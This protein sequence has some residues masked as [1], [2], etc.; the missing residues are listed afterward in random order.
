M[1]VRVFSKGV[2]SAGMFRIPRTKRESVDFVILRPEG[3]NCGV[4]DL[5]C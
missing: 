4:I 2:V 5:I 1:E 3:R